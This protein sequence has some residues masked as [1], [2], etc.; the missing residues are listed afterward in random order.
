MRRILISNTAKRNI[1]LFTAAFL[2]WGVFRNLLWEVP[3]TYSFS[4]LYG[5]VLVILWAIT[6]QKRITDDR[7]RSLMLL[8]AI[9]LLLHFFIQFLR[10]ELF[11][12]NMTAQRYY[13]MPCI[14]RLRPSRFYSILPP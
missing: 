6:V 8:S 9:F 5:G 3:F 4:S 14:S 7:L 11:D 2:L 1:A 10:Y 13:G 12:G